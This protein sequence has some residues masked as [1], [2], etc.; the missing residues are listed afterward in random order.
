MNKET[1]DSF[2]E[3]YLKIYNNY[4]VTDK[5]KIIIDKDRNVIN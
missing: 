4:K 2:F 1:F 5:E 3:P